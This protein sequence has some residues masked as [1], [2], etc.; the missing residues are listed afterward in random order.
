MG[1]IN[2]HLTLL[3]LLRWGSNDANK[4]QHKSFNVSYAHTNFQSNV[5]AFQLLRA[6]Y[7]HNDDSSQIPLSR[8]E[9]ES[10]PC[11]IHLESTMAK[12]I[13]LLFTSELFD[14]RVGVVQNLIYR[15]NHTPVS[16]P[17]SNLTLL[18]RPRS[19]CLGTSNVNSS[20]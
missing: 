4:S 15:N 2:D 1:H 10:E 8:N 9:G 14:N 18:W 17:V 19:G 5:L 20:T 16:T 6:V 13:R 3:G 11:G 12:S 7:A